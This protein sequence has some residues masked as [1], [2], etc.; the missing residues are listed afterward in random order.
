M[1]AKNLYR[2]FES[3]ERVKRYLDFDPGLESICWYPSAGIDFRHIP[4]FERQKQLC[5]RDEGMLEPP[6]IYFMSDLDVERVYGP[7]GDEPFVVGEDLIKKYESEGY[8]ENYKTG[9]E[10]VNG[11]RCR[12]VVKELIPLTLCKRIWNPCQY[13]LTFPPERSSEKVWFLKLEMEY[14]FQSSELDSCFNRR[15]LSEPCGVTYTIHSEP[16]VL[17]FPYE[18]INFLVDFILAEAIQISHLVHVRDGGGS[19]GGSRFP[20]NFFYQFYEE[21]GL[22]FILRSWGLGGL[23]FCSCYSEGNHRWDDV[24]AR[25]M[26]AFSDEEFCYR[27]VA[28]FPALKERLRNYLLRRGAISKN[29]IADLFHD[30]HFSSSCHLDAPPYAEV[31]IREHVR[32]CYLQFMC[33]GYR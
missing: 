24:P 22:Q 2:L 11:G 7:E 31:Y 13:L 4:Y 21:I 27:L 25:L 32:C 3:D 28:E 12:L 5:I 6:R 8:D 15:K 20:M 16:C 23:G 1:R 30:V 14:T 26:N 33:G 17:Y 29:V 18:N 9:L 10:Y 19:F